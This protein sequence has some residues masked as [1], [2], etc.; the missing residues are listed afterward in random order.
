[1]RLFASAF[2]IYIFSLQNPLLLLQAD[3][4]HYCSHL[5]R[6]VSSKV[7]VSFHCQDTVES[8]MEELIMEG[9]QDADEEEGEPSPT[10]RFTATV[11]KAGTTLLFHLVSEYGEVKI[12]G[13]ATCPSTAWQDATGTLPKSLYQGPEFSE[14]AEDVQEAFYEHLENELGIDSNVA[15]FVAMYADYQEQQWY[16]KFL[17]SAEKV[18]G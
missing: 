6:S 9:M 13:V 12:E 14:L 10:V 4:T 3:D 8:N 7:H 17:Q 16:V 11:S 2:C 18:V 5:H 15:T 1:M